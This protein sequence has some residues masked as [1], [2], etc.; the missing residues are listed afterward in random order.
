MKNLIEEFVEAT[1]NCPSPEIFR[2]WCMISMIA[3]TLTRHTWT[4]ILDDKKLF[5]NMYVMLVAEPGIGKTV[6]MDIVKEMMLK[7]KDDEDNS[8]LTFS[9]DEATRQQ[10]IEQIGNTFQ[11]APKMVEGEHGYVFFLA[12]FSTIMP[13]PDVTWMQSVAR[14]WECPNTYNKATKE[15]GSDFLYWPY[16]NILAGVQPEWFHDGFPK[17]SYNMGLPART[18][19]IWS[20]EQ[21][22]VQFFRKVKQFTKEDHFM[23][24][25]EQ[26]R[27]MWGE[28]EWT[29]EAA[30]MFQEWKNN[31]YPPAP[32]APLM[33]HYCTRR[34]M[35]A[36]KLALIACAAS[37]PGSMQINKENL[38]TAWRYLFEAER[39]MPT[40]LQ[41]VGG[42]TFKL[43]ETAIVHFVGAE[44][45]RTGR[46]VHESEVRKRLGDLVSTNWVQPIINELI[47]QQRIRVVG[48]P[49]SGQ[50]NR[51]LRPGKEKHDKA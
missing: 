14:I 35:H 42:N 9:S 37:N 41:A 28:V 2:R 8:Y 40:A 21:P 27:R 50:G 22:E 1:A 31:G 3:V 51:L 15:H 4:C 19:F 38:E 32:T 7:L 25:L 6:P 10:I 24:R 45:A 36:G 48:T 47:L 12:E 34:S 26:I 49:A 46:P 5:P 16:V 23:E 18:M 29:D 20:D 44:Y 33:K 11:P 30:E 13:E 17:G 43:S 39:A